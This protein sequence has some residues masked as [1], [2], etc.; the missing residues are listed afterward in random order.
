MID[1]LTEHHQYKI[2]LLAGRLNSYTGSVILRNQGESVFCIVAA[3]DVALLRQAYF[4]AMNRSSRRKLRERLFE[5]S[6]I[7]QIDDDLTV[8]L[9][10]LQSENGSVRPFLLFYFGRHEDSEK[11]AVLT[12]KNLAYMEYLLY[13]TQRAWREKLYRH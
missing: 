4:H 6:S 8:D 7:A 13:V 1:A 11:Y 9:F 5:T 2:Q 12:V 3:N 10:K